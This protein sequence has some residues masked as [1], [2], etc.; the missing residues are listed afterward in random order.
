MRRLLTRWQA[1]SERGQALVETA[2]ITMLILF[3]AL[4]TFDIGR[5]IAAHLALTEATQEGSIYA[6][7]RLYHKHPA[8]AVTIDQ[9]QTRVRQSSTTAEVVNAVVTEVAC[10]PAPGY[11]T[12]RSTY[13]L[14]VISPLG[15]LAFGPTFALSVEINATNLNEDCS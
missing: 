2:L 15:Q 14:P 4:A 7:Y 13:D 1:A 12:I 11:L 8:V 3:I 9:V 6:G 10:A 5:G